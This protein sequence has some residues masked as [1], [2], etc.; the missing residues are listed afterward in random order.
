[1]PCDGAERAPR[2]DGG[3]GEVCG[4]SESPPPPRP[5]A[6]R[7]F[8]PH[9]RAARAAPLIVAVALGPAHPPRSALAYL[10][11]ALSKQELFQWLTL[12]PVK[13][14][15]ALLFLDRCGG[16]K[17]LDARRGSAGRM[18]LTLPPF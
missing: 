6:A 7:L 18:G 2:T 14:Y 1:M 5:I 15:H 10:L 3:S 11:D 13:V 4:L 17:A 12:T 16:A 8:S 9:C